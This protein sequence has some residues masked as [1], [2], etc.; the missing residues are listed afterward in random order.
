VLHIGFHLTLHIVRGRVDS[1]VLAPWLERGGALA[2]S[3]FV[4]AA[5]FGRY[6]FSRLM[7][8]VI[9]AMT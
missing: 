6:P 2:E 3:G 4:A 7:G 1:G 8:K 5:D 9:E